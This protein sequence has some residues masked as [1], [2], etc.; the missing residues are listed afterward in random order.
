MVHWARSV[1]C[2]MRD[3]NDNLDM[4]ER[5]TNNPSDGNP[6]LQ[7]YVLHMRENL[8]HLSVSPNYFRTNLKPCPESTPTFSNRY[9]STSIDPPWREKGT[10]NHSW[11]G[12]PLKYKSTTPSF[13]RGSRE[14]CL[15]CSVY[16]IPVA[17]VFGSRCVQTHMLKFNRDVAINKTFQTTPMQLESPPSQRPDNFKARPDN[18]QTTPRQL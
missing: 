7:T 6:H 9:N 8:L 10:C 5:F 13:K 11:G 1:I 16:V 12:S 15:E 17:G 18:L 4:L 14:A 3:G 2:Q